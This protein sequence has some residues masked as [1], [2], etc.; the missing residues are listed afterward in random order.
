[1]RRVG[2]KSPDEVAGPGCTR[3]RKAGDEVSKN[4]ARLGLIRIRRF[5]DF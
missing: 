4:E 5:G 2:D 3:S 1:V